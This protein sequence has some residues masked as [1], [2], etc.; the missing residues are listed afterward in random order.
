MVGDVD[1]PVAHC[2]A[3]SRKLWVAR[4]DRTNARELVGDLEEV[5]QSVTIIKGQQCS[6]VFD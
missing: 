5:L 1:V 4:L 3:E 2:L 6:R